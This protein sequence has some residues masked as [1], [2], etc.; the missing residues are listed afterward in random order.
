MMGKQALRRLAGTLLAIGGLLGLLAG[1]LH[2]QGGVG[3]NFHQV[4]T[5]MLGSAQWPV[6]HW[7]ALTYGLSATWALWLLLDSGWLSEFPVAWAGAR[8]AIVAGLFMSVQ[9][10]VELASRVELNAY[11]AGQPASLLALVEPMQTVGW[12]AL[13]LG[14]ALLALGAPAS[15]PLLVRAAGALGAAALF[16]GGVAVEGFHLAPLG[17]LFAVGGLTFVWLIW[18]GARLAL[19]RERLQQPAGQRKRDTAS[20]AGSES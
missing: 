20:L 18:T 10:A 6:A 8:L 11:A 15:A 5:A 4:V 12:P 14:Y 17:P 19:G 1:V 2:P 16:V 13:G 9:F 7:L 3:G